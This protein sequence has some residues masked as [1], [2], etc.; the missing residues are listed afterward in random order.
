[1]AP[2][3]IIW[4]GEEIVSDYSPRD[5]RDSGPVDLDAMRRDLDA[6]ALAAKK[7]RENDEKK[8]NDGDR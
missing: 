5:F 1:M 8:T 6:A 3:T 7:K 4:K 2:M